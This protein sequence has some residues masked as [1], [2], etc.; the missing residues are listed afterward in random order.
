[1][2]KKITCCYA[3]L[4]V[5]YVQLNF[6]QAAKDL[7]IIVKTQPQDAAA[8]AL[9]NTFNQYFFGS[10]QEEQGMTAALKSYYNR[11]NESPFVFGGGGRGAPADFQAQL[12][13]AA[14]EAQQ[15]R[16]EAE[17]LKVQLQGQQQDSQEL[18][19]L[20]ALVAQL[21]T[22]MDKLQADKDR[23]EKDLAE[24]KRKLEQSGAVAAERD[25]LRTELDALRTENAHLG[26]QARDCQRKEQA[27]RE[28]NDRAADMIAR[29]TQENQ[30]LSLHGGTNA[31][32]QAQVG[33]L[34]AENER[35]RRDLAASR[36][37]LSAQPAGAGEDRQALLQ[38][39]EDLRRIVNSLTQE[40][41]GKDLLIQ[42]A[43][44]DADQ[45]LKKR[46]EAAD[47]ESAKVRQEKADLEAKIRQLE[48]KLRDCEDDFERKMRERIEIVEGRAEDTCKKMEKATGAESII[49][50]LK[51][52]KAD[53]DGFA[54]EENV[55]ARK[56]EET[57]RALQQQ[58]RDLQIRN[59]EPGSSS[60]PQE[61]PESPQ[62]VGKLMKEVSNLK[63][64]LSE[65]KAQNT[66]L[67][68]ANADV[69]KE[70][71]TLKQARDAQEQALRLCRAAPGQGVDIKDLD[72]ELITKAGKIRDL[73]EKNRKVARERDALKLQ[74]AD[75]NTAQIEMANRIQTLTEK[76]K[77]YEKGKRPAVTLP[78]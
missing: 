27:A 39:I 3:V 25:A 33:A 46:M 7:Q 59:A 57:V 60:A 51:K 68:Q 22:S 43:H 66:G 53:A 72:Q 55:K 29:L 9:Q 44:L 40:I 20:R 6:A 14:A 49:A 17:R 50:R 75:L 8:T 4:I 12:D 48:Q 54:Q 36:A 15:A 70:N 19:R 28:A 18:A 31:D 52:E 30:A 76:L 35:L 24:A 23:L 47:I 71:D 41:K 16:Q 13:R 1:V 5:G 45:A 77:T 21:Q 74:N 65:L 63:V 37:A 56:A 26:T 38:Q 73:E 62:R 2:F 58:I 11:Y 10:P 42:Q 78:S 32:L 64:K 67:L 69:N 61:Q 34:T